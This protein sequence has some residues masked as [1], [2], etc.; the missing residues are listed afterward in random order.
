MEKS[1]PRA[2]SD[3]ERPLSWLPAPGLETTST[4]KMLRR[5]RAAATP[6]FRP[7]PA[8]AH[9]YQGLGSPAD[10]ALDGA[11]SGQ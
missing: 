2:R 6:I 11:R 7:E 10:R 1:N 3:T 4:I 9:G 8:S 5:Q